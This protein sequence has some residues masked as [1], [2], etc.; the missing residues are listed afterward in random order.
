M[1]HGLR[2]SWFVAA[3]LLVLL[4][5]PVFRNRAWAAG[6]FTSP[7]TSTASTPPEDAWLAPEI[8]SGHAPSR[9]MIIKNG[10]RGGAAALVLDKPFEVSKLYG[11][12]AGNP[13]LGY[14]CGYHWALMIDYRD[15]PSET[16]DIN[17]HCETFRRDPEGSWRVLSAALKRAREHPSHFV[18]TVL[19]PDAARMQR[20]RGALGDRFGIIAATSDH[21]AVVASKKP[22]S[23]QRINELRTACRGLAEVQ[24][25]Q[26][27]DTGN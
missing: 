4:L 7:A 22:W 6:K 5:V 11:A 18:V 24:P 16:I 17:E 3:G 23:A 13:R 20:V 8:T 21:S 25:R 2:L 27:Y 12:L 9:I 14:T 1:R 15:S 10:W 26:E 19:A